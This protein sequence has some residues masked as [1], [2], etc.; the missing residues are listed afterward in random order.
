MS[1]YRTV[2]TG[3]KTQSGGVKAGFSIV[4]PACEAVP[5]YLRANQACE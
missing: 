1:T 3:P 4:V 5:D 2:Q